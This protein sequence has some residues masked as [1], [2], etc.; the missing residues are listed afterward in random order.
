MLG[1]WFVIVV[2]S[3][4]AIFLVFRH[5]LYRKEIDVIA[6]TLEFVNGNDTNRKIDTR[7]NAKEIRVLAEQINRTIDRGK[8]ERIRL[9][10]AQRTFKEEM[11]N[12]SHDFRTPLTS[13]VGYLQ[14]LEEGGVTPE[15]KPDY[16]RVMSR[17][18]GDLIQLLDD[19][20]EFARLESDE[21]LLDL[22]RVNV[23]DALTETLS[24]FY[25]DFVAKDSEPA[26]DLPSVPVYLRADK[27]ALKRIFQNLVQNYFRHG[28]GRLLISVKQE[29]NLVDISFQN[30]TTAVDRQAVERLFYRFYTAEPSRNNGTTG[31][32]LAIVKHLAEKM[33]GEVN[34]TVEYEA[35]TIRIRFNTDTDSSPQ[36]GQE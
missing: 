4:V 23:C 15:K 8:R 14:M 12:L 34:A 2:L 1:L 10:Q 24:L 18:A 26:L 9:A 33:K 5:L 19:F 28:E 3:A 11:T 13:I 35:L 22:E 32:G 31:L 29:G 21:Y 17:R 27:G 30:R 20:F 6:Q 16:Y 36:P 25:Y 7:S